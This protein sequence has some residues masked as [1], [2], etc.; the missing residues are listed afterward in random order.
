MFHNDVQE[1]HAVQFHLLTE[2]NIILQI[3]QIFIWSNLA[4]NVENSRR[5]FP[6]VPFPKYSSSSQIS[7]Q[8]ERGEITLS[9]E[10]KAASVR[11][12]ESLIANPKLG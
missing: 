1:I 2:G 8:L 12:N 4:E 3:A 7:R 5:E 10:A 9:S 11:Q 6:L